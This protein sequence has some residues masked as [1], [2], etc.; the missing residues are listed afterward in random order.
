MGAPT[1]VVT[2]VCGASGSLIEL[3]GGQQNPFRTG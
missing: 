3:G 1:N 2:V